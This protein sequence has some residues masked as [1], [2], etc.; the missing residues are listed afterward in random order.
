MEKKCDLV[1]W[2]GAGVSMDMP[3][4]LP[5]GNELISFVWEQV[6]MYPDKILDIWNAVNEVVKEDIHTANYPRL[7][8]VL[9]S[10]AYA[11]RYLVEGKFFS[12][13]ESF[14]EVQFNYNHLLL[15]ILL[16]NG[17]TIFTANFDLC[18][19]KAYEFLFHE[20]LVGQKKKRKKEIIYRTSRGAEI[21]HFHGT[22][23]SG[24][25]MGATL[26]NIMN[27]VEH[28]V[29]TRI[30]S[31]FKK[32]KRNFFVGYSLSDTY[33]INSIIKRI[34]CTRDQQ[35]TSRNYVCNHDGR[36]RMISSKA[37]D[38]FGENVKIINENTTLFLK[39]VC[40]EIT[41]DIPSK[42]VIAEKN[43]IS[44]KKEFLKRIDVTR[45]LKLIA[46]I[47]L[48]NNLNIAVD[49][50]D[51]AIINEY[52]EIRENITSSKLFVLEYHLAANSELYYNM[53]KDSRLNEEQKAA[54]HRRLIMT[55]Q[56]IWKL[57]NQLE[58]KEQEIAINISQGLFWNYQ[59]G[60]LLSGYIKVLK[61]FVIQKK[62]SKEYLEKVRT[63]LNSLNGLRNNN[64]I[65]LVL[66]AAYYRYY[67]LVD[68][69][70]N[71]KKSSYFQMAID[72]YYD[73]G[74]LEGIISTYL[75]EALGTFFIDDGKLSLQENVDLAKANEI[76]NLIGAFRYRAVL[77]QYKNMLN[78]DKL[79]EE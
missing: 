79:C 54:L 56:D 77:E 69:M 42:D 14:A 18:I 16:Y 37:K 30:V 46:T 57:E 4:K 5:S 71:Y 26:E 8:L 22:S 31:C 1:I 75:D 64:S 67:M 13:F 3:T 6:V 7:E 72:M 35:Y 65:N 9:S 61:Y 59:K 60:E 20:N 76:V 63:I 41:N 11:E 27:I 28:A 34:Y 68:M 51:A 15:A 62:V 48:L 53:Y 21:I 49:K 45:N 2:V 36:D 12:G 10:V 52:N 73:I 55:Q 47:T 38:I 58:K 40:K 33:D 43:Y 74:R 23:V 44:W 66:Y 32:E 78:D 39:S 17:A 19:E 25:S 24:W 29:Y 70:T 50:I